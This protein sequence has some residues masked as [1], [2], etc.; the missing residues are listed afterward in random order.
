MTDSKRTQVDPDLVNLRGGALDLLPRVVVPLETF[1]LFADDP[2]PTVRRY[3]DSL[4]PYAASTEVAQPAGAS[5]RASMAFCFA[6]CSLA[7]G[8]AGGAFIAQPSGS[9]PASAA[10]AP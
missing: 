2:P 6:I 10:Q 7:A 3:H 9:A 1:Q 8:A 5:R 4:S